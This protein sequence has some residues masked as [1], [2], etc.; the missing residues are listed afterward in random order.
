LLV[1][2]F[3]IVGALVELHESLVVIAAE[4]LEFLPLQALKVAPVPE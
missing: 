1:Q 3:P 2:T 4:I